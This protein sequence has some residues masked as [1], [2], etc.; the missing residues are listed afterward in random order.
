MISSIDLLSTPYL[1]VVGFVGEQLRAHIVWCSY[2]G[3]GHVILILQNT[4][5]AKVPHFDDVSLGQKDILGL[6]VPVQNT[7]LM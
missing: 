4:G 2:E 7:L 6:Q 1:V 3:A 5:D